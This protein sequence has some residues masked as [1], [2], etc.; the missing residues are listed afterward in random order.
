M[1]DTPKTDAIEKRAGG[2]IP[3]YALDQFAKLERELAEA[4]EEVTR[5]KTACDKFSED[6]I[7]CTIQEQRDRLAE[8]LRIARLHITGEA[9]P[10]IDEALAVIDATLAAVKG[11]NEP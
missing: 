7:L 3:A 11:G 8:A 10:T 9:L 5:L 4:R 6:E 2:L 1:S